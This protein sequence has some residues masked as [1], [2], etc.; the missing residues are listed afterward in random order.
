MHRLDD[1]AID[2]TFAAGPRWPG[3]R[4]TVERV[5]EVLEPLATPRRCARFA[6]AIAARLESVTLVLDAPH[7]PHNGAAIL[8][9]ADAFG[10]CEMH[11]VP[12]GEQ[13]LIGRRI[14]KGSQRWVDVTVHEGP[15]A[16]VGALRRRGYTLVA[17][18]PDGELVPEQLATIPRVALLLGNEHSGLSEALL[19]AADT[20]VR[21]PMR[22][23]VESLNVSVAAAILLAFATRG[24]SGDLPPAQQRFLYA[25]ALFRSV[26]RAAEVLAAFH[27]GRPPGRPGRS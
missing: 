1:D 17:T 7:D 11:V 27:A 24:R 19:S 12:R 20:S 18:T 22:G 25:R 3:E 2:G 6:D 21:I 16:A 8:R 15:A 9:S 13:F 10:L 26:P 4:W 23:F 14:A 5:I